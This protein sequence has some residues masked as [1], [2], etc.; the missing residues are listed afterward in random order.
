MNIIKWAQVSDLLLITINLPNFEQKQINLDE[1]TLFIKG[2]SNGEECILNINFLYEINPDKSSGK[3]IDNSIEFTIYKKVPSMWNKLTREK[4]ETYESLDK[5]LL[6]TDPPP[7]PNKYFDMNE[8]YVEEND[9]FEI[10]DGT[11]SNFSEEPN[12]NIEEQNDNNEEQNDN[13]T[14]NDSEYST[15]ILEIDLNQDDY[16]EAEDS[17][18]DS[19]DLNLEEVKL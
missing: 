15:E 3:I 9:S 11:D 2:F 18:S 10:S 13:E 4:I 6:K 7:N 12:D 5:D 14:Q 17:D 16:S 19:L 1:K 8:N